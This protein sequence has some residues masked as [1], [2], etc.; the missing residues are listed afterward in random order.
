MLAIAKITKKGQVT[1]PQK[2]REKLNSNI[3]EFDI[4]G[5]NVVIRPVKNV[6]GSLVS[7]AKKGAI[8]FKEMR[9][10]AWGEIIKEKYG[11]KID[12]R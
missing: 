2:I 4:V 5:N 6:A 10:Q 3:I 11:K 9:E 7:Y 1:I 12:R 8:S